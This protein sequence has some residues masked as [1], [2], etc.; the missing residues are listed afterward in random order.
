MVPR[1]RLPRIRGKGIPAVLRTSQRASGVHAPQGAHFVSQSMQSRAELPLHLMEECPSR[2]GRAAPSGTTRVRSECA[3]EPCDQLQE[4]TLYERE[5]E[6]YN[7]E[8]RMKLL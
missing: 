4:L 3:N 5:R 8:L 6:S 2:Y 7:A 1:K